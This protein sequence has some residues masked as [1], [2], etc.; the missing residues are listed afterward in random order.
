MA[1]VPMWKRLEGRLAR[2]FHTRRRPLSGSN[3]GG[4]SDDII[5]P[6]IYG[7]CK[8]AKRHTVFTLFKEEAAKARK[9]KK[10]PVL[11]LGQKDSKGMLLVIDSRDFQTVAL[12]YLYPGEIQ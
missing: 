1:R 9:E 10:V 4:G 8:Y 6:R 12:E 5:H 3:Q 2:F 11:A 7:S